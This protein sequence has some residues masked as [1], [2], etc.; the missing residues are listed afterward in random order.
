MSFDKTK[1]MRNAERFLT[2]G[3]IR[4]AIG[5]YK[6]IVENDPK[7]FS[8]LNILGDLYVKSSERQ[9]AVGCFTKVAEHYSTQGFAHKAIAIYNKLSRINP[10]SIEISAKLAELYQ[11]R[12]SMAEARK[13]YIALA[14]HYQ[15]KGQKIEALTIWK[16]IA[17]LDPNNT[18]I[19]LRIAE[20]CWQEEQFDEAAKAFIE[21]G[22]R[23]LKQGKFEQSQTAFSRALEI[24]KSNLPALRG[25]VKAKI[26]LGYTDEATT[27]LEEAL[28]EQPFNR[29]VLHLLVECY[30]D[31]DKAEDAERAVLKLVE[32]E[33]ANYPK[34]LDLVKAY[35]KIDD[36]NS[37]ARILSMS[38]EHLLVGGQSEDFL[39]WTNEILTRNPEQMDA[40]RLLVRFHGWQRDES[41]IRE[42]LE[43][44]AEIA[45]L[46]ESLEDEHFALS[47]LVMIAPQESGYAKRL[48]EINAEHDFGP[49][50][51]V[52]EP[53]ISTEVPQFETFSGEQAEQ[54]E[55]KEFAFND[56]YSSIEISTNGSNGNG[57]GEYDYYQSELDAGA[58]EEQ[59]FDELAAQPDGEL[60]LAD[61]YRLQKE[62]EG[63]QFYIA[64]G[65]ND[66]A[67][68]T[69]VVLEAEFGVQPELE[70]LRQCIGGEESSVL[71]DTVITVESPVIETEIYTSSIEPEIVPFVSEEEPQVVENTQETA[72][73]LDDLKSEF[74]LEEIEA[75][76][77]SDYETHYHMA[78][79]Y[80]EMGLMEDAIR[81]FQDAINLVE[82][83]DSARR[84][85]KCSNL[86]GHCFM[87]KKMPNLALMWYKRCL[88]VEGLHDEEK[89]ALY[90]EIGDAYEAAGE[91]DQAVDYFERLYAE[92]VDFRDVGKRLENLVEN[93]LP[94]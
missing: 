5:E 30:L 55:S 87:E 39:M 84:F 67:L 77:G 85:F 11:I 75:E 50:E 68:K 27:I 51:L 73:F 69:L 78:T 21:V 61:R 16:Q 80:K 3:K 43:R 46:N 36:L 64:Q 45:R 7:D 6:R 42:S 29:D 33:P 28:A 41:A 59:S 22:S 56:E 14:E 83:N 54:E 12:G 93:N 25:L 1:A 71:E 47:Q 31:M 94:V 86:L 13:H 60:N 79:A 48:Q 74:D 72:N 88:E 49:T 17:E 23:L 65:Y 19:Y 57:A 40:L 10:D 20:T 24:K 52:I 62:V 8:T 18:D 4:A 34:F 91:T 53:L 81:E 35:L 26:G 9:K 89:H 63:I 15:R 37:A 2:Q 92:N 32:Q 38:S 44:M 70:E 82:V 58:I 76:D 90:Y 66:L